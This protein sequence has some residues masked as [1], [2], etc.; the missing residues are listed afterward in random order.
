[1]SR[2]IVVCEDCN[3]AIVRDRELVTDRPTTVCSHLRTATY[4]L[5]PAQF[6]PCVCVSTCGDRDPDGAGTCK[7]LPYK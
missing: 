6:D 1:M 5:A 4:V 3:V 7:G 2:E